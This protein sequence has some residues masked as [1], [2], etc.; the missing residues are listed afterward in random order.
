[1]PSGGARARSGPAPDP[2]ALRRD[3]KSDQAGWKTLPN[4]GRRGRTPAWPLSVA[5]R[6]ER[7]M[8][9]IEWKRPQ[10]IEWERNGQ[11]IE[12]ALYVRRLVE[13]E[14]PGSPVTL[15]KLVRT[16]REDLGL[17]QP[18]MLRLRWKIAMDETAARRETRTAP[19]A[20][21]R[22]SARDRFKVVTDGPG[23]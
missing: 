7:D 8:W 15:S 18:G 20:P 16:M 13:S 10:A 2:N 5:T 11:H 14:K 22:T 6:R 19:A 9:A 4:E 3:R 21:G 12:V 17:T 23:A 1:M